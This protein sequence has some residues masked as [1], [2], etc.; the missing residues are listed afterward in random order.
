MVNQETTFAIASLDG[1]PVARLPQ[2]R[3][4]GE[5]EAWAPP[6]RRRRRAISR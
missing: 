5:P 1:V 6:P 2:A 4:I 3:V